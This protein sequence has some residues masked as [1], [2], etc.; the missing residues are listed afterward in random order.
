MGA[1]LCR[2]GAIAEDQA[3]ALAPQLRPKLLNVAGHV[4]GELRPAPVLVGE[5]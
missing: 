5:G 1:L 3:A 4:V 2:L